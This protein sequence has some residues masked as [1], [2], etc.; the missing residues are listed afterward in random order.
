[1]SG[2]ASAWHDRAVFRGPRG[3]GG[4]S[5]RPNEGHGQTVCF[6][7]VLELTFDMP[8]LAVPQPYDFVRSTERFRAYGRDLA[9]AWNESALHRVVAG[10]EVR[11]EAAPGGVLLT[12]Q[13]G[14]PLARISAAQTP[15]GVR[16]RRPQAGLTPNLGV[17]D[18]A[19]DHVSF[20]LGLPFDLA[21][22]WAWAQAEAVLAGLAQPLA[23]FRPPLQP[24]PWEA[25]VTSI[26]AQQ[27]SLHSA[28][29]VRARLVERFG[30]RI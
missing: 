5:H 18:D 28:F 4:M 15:E 25:L 17:D 26:T 27:V 22:F 14:D 11:I 6:G 19:R 16:L 21:A 7:P 13:G 3:P 9:T 20:L 8:V 12:A 1:M 23:G 2:S 24:D 29:A 10:R 30:T